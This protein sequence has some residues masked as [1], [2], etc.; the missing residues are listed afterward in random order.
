MDF[1]KVI[2]FAFGIAFMVILY[3]IIYYALKIMYK[4]LKVGVR[5]KQSSVK[6]EYGIEV[7]NSGDNSNLEQGSIFL[8]RDTITIGRKETNTI[9]LDDQF[10]S[11]NHALIKIKNNIVVI[12][13]LESTNGTFINGKKIYTNSSLKA[14]DKIKIGNATFKLIETEKS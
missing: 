14:D 7:L 4:D 9:V 11:G 8:L 3:L 5:R 10:V 1:S 12:E 13:D 2:S 6:Q